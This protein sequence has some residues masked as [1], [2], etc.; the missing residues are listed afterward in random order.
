MSQDESV[1]SHAPAP[2]RGRAARLSRR[3]AFIAGVVLFVAFAALRVPLLLSHGLWAD[4]LFSLAMATGHS[5]EHPADVADAS[6]GDFVELPQAVTAEFYAQHLDHREPRAAPPRVVRAVYLSDTSPPGYYVLLHFWT[7]LL[8]TSDAALRGF[9][10]L[11]AMATFPVLWSLARRLGGRWAAVSAA[12]FYTFAPFCIFYSVEGRMYSM[13]WFWSAALMWLALRAR[14]GDNLGRPLVMSAWIIVSVAGLLTHYFFAF[15]WL[16]SAL[17]LLL[18][19]GALKRLWLLAAAA[20]TAVLIIPWYLRL[21][22]S[23]QNWRVTGDW[24]N[25]EPWPGYN[26]LV[27]VAQLPWRFFSPRGDWGVRPHW[28]LPAALALLLLAILSA[29]RVRWCAP[30]RQLAWLSVAAAC[31]GLAAFDLWRGTYA[32]AISRYAI[33][34]MPAAFVLAGVALGSVPLRTRLVIAILFAASCLIG[35]RRMY[36]NPGRAAEPFDLAARQI[37]EAAGPQDLVIVHSIPSGVTGVA[38]YLEMY[39]PPEAEPLAFAAWVGQLGQRRMP[40]DILDLTRGREQVFVVVGHAVG[41]PAPELEWLHDHATLV[42]ERSYEAV[43]VYT[44]RVGP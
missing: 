21:P 36:I 19:G 29:R 11:W 20:A 10:L 3:A 13:L 22:G 37:V 18:H 26:L 25:I 32:S 5:L 9:S 16:A 7:R 31:L 27:V 30:R 41:E 2:A 4:E 42:E 39:R 44:F 28:E 14:G 15:V 33:A 38:R 40:E 43:H 17:W 24:L 6:S 12:F 23:L 8:G 34:G 35:F 1:R